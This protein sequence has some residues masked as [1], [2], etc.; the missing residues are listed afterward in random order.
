MA[1]DLWSKFEKWHF[2][3][4]HVWQ[5]FR[6]YA[7]QV[8]ATGRSKYSA[9]AIIHRIRWHVEI[10]TNSVDEFK[11]NNNW[12]P[13][14][15]RLYMYMFESAKGF[16]ELRPIIDNPSVVQRVVFRTTI[17]KNKNCSRLRKLPKVGD[18]TVLEGL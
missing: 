2:A 10:D 6:T 8:R 12:S 3:N 11:I 15:A 13:Y 5:L 17:G 14:Y 16:F 7:D 9:R 1:D 18:Q 4:F